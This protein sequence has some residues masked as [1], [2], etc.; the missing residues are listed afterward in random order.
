M[1]SDHTGGSVV[2]DLEGVL[3]SILTDGLAWHRSSRC[4]GGDCVEVATRADLVFVRNSGNPDGSMLVIRRV[5]WARL[6]TRVKE[7]RAL[8]S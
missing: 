4:N 3:D 1:R 8:H 2:P 6:I 7:T 5:R